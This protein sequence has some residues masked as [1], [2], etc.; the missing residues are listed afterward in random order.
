MS[1]PPATTTPTA[2]TRAQRPAL[3]PLTD[4]AADAAITAACRTLSLPTVRT[5]A[6]P[7]AEAAA[8]ERLSHKAYLVEVLSAEC[9]DRDSRRRIRRVNEAR[10]PR[11]K[12][13]E[14]LDLTTLPTL[15]AATLTHLASGAWIHAGEPVVLLG[16]SGTGKTHLLIGLGTA[17]AEQGLRVRYV[18]TAAL[19]NELV[20]AASEKQL[21][22]VV[23]RY[24]RLDLLCLDEVGYVHLDPRGAELLF[25]IITAREERASIACASNAP[26]SEWG[27]TFT[28]PR[29]AAAVVD[30]LTFR[31]HIIQTGTESYRL[32]TTRSSKTAA[33]Q[34]E[35]RRQATT[36]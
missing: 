34:R 36:S 7:I 2:R 33:P 15:P 8:R 11:S 25:Q 5:A 31:A 29:L 19:V 21:S 13:L 28:D 10:F 1:P 30:R 23:N 20:E 32:R 22:R 17:A 26:F 12:R 35:P 16:D 18:T 3:K 6:A 4:A 24:A 9:D 14:D 27:T